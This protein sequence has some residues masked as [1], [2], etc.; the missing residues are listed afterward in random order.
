MAADE[1]LAVVRT[2]EADSALGMRTSW[3]YDPLKVS[4]LLSGNK[5]REL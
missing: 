3:M 2:L 4:M 1:E 5:G